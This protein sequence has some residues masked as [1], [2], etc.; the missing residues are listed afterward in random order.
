MNVHRLLTGIS[1]AFLIAPNLG[2]S[3]ASAQEESDRALLQPLLQQKFDA[4]DAAAMPKVVHDGA[5]ARLRF[6]DPKAAT[7]RL[8][9]ILRDLR[10]AVGHGI[11]VNLQIEFADDAGAR[12]RVPTRVVLGEDAGDAADAPAL[13]VEDSRP[14]TLIM[15]YGGEGAAGRPGADIEVVAAG[16]GQTIIALGGDGGRGT[17]ETASRHGGDGGSVVLGHVVDGSTIASAVMGGRGGDGYEPVVAPTG[18]E[19]GSTQSPLVGANGADG[20]D[21]GPGGP[22]GQGTNGDNGGNGGKGGDVNTGAFCGLSIT[23]EGGN[24]GKGGSG[25]DATTGLPGNGGNGGKGGQ[26]T[27]NCGGGA[28]GQ[29]LNSSKGGNGGAGGTGGRSNTRGGNGGDGGQGGLAAATTSCTTGQVSAIGGDGGRGGN[30]GSTLFSGGFGGDGG[31]G[32]NKGIAITAAGDSRV[33][34][35][36]INGAIGVGGLA[37]TSAGGIPGNPGMSP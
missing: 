10:A 5:G 32:G 4:L 34:K 14:S 11:D 6:A 2:C 9:L 35:V 23:A 29:A 30:G 33:I 20:T 12:V 37:G 28:S 8:P 31:D 26:G 27:S 16:L 22:G 21:G 15:A 3:G 13:H 1:L 17:P 19:I 25:S 7:A 36:Q 18:G 24:G